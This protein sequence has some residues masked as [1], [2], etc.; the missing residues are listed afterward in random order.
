[1]VGG[2]FDFEFRER[3]WQLTTIAA[4][5]RLRCRITGNFYGDQGIFVRRTIFTRLGG[6]PP[7]LLFEDLLL[8]QHMRRYGRTVLL[9]GQRTRTSGRRLLAPHWPRAVGLMTWLLLLH[10]VGADTDAYAARYHKPRT[11]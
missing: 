9:R 1:V 11:G 3:A 10:A 7:K 8:S 6:F 5:N 2:A 4:L